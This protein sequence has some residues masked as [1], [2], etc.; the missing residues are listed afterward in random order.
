M[1]GK[2]KKFK[3]VRELRGTYLVGTFLGFRLIK[4]NHNQLYEWRIEGNGM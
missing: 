3:I 4:E 1:K 2:K